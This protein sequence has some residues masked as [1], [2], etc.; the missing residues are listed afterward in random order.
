MKIFIA[1]TYRDNSIIE[2]IS[3]NVG[4]F[5]EPL[6]SEPFIKAKTLESS[7][8]ILVPHDAYY[9]DRFPDY[10]NYLNALSKSKLV[11]F[12]DRGD[13][14][15][16]PKITNSVA[17][18]VAI[19][20]GESRYRK[21]VIP[22]NIENL[23]F[24]PYKKLE[25]K[26]TVSFVGFMPKISMGRVKHTLQQSPLHPIKGNG[27]VVRLLMDRTLSK[28]DIAYSCTPRNSYGALDVGQNDLGKNRAEYL[29][30]ISES[31]LV[32]CPRGDAN[33]SARFY[34]TL[35]AGRIPCVPDTSIVFPNVEEVKLNRL[36]IKFPFRHKILEFLVAE[37]FKSI[38]TQSEYNS[39]QRDLRDF[40]QRN[41][42]FEPIVKNIF[43]S[44]KNGFMKMANFS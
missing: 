17:L 5:Q 38:R 24:L 22:Y 31:D 8:A 34:E 37:Y 27:A 41:L 15:K 18:R 13:F 20:P 36:L 44:D 16:K 28:A 7:D 23:S 35:S 21:I 2:L 25:A 19:N 33:Q 43:T 30:S 40:F 14:P 32:A 26:L 12:S 6:T 3:G 4:L 1:E 39:I 11:I 29:A 42:R 10:L 9:F